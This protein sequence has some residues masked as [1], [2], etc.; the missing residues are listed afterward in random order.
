MN[1]IRFSDL[2]LEP[3]ARLVCKMLGQDVADKFNIPRY[4][5]CTS[6]AKVLAALLYT[7]ELAAQGIVPVEPSQGSELVHIPGLLPVRKADLSPAVQTQSG[8]HFFAQYVYRCCQPA[9]EA[10]AGYFINSFEDLEPSCIDSLRSFPYSQR[11]HS[12]VAI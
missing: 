4:V 10:A 11:A 3:S 8:L 7:P 12:K 2:V 9:V 5:I 1:I 6:P